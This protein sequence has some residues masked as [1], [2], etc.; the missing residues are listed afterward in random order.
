MTLLSILGI[1]GRAAKHTPIILTGATSSLTAS[2]R[3][4]DSGD[5]HEHT[6][7]VTVWATGQPNAVRL[8]EE[9][10]RV[11]SSF[12]G[13]CLPDRLAWAE[14]LAAEIARDMACPWDSYA[15]VEVEIVRPKERLQARWTRASLIHLRR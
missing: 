8:R 3:S 6:W 14:D 4:R 5:V 2:H 10:D 12:S 9:L 15:V 11:L 13:K 1:G 7:N